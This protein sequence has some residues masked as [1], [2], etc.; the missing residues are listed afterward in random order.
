MT[1]P[2]STLREG[3]KAIVKNIDLE[4][5]MKKRLIE[6]GITPET[7]L[8]VVNKQKS[9]YMIIATENFKLAFDSYIAK[10]IIVQPIN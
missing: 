8:T 5:I 1:T 6:L 9:G 3:F 4:P 10:H 2:V 7:K